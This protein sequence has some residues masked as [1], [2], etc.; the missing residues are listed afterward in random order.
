MRGLHRWAIDGEHGGD[1][2]LAITQGEGY[3]VP[4][5]Q[6]QVLLVEL[7]REP[8]AVPEDEGDVTLLEDAL[9]DKGLPLRYCDDLGQ[10]V[11]QPDG[12]YEV[13]VTESL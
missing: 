7:A 4:L 10:H 11:G 12:V 5:H 9:V 8:F 1:E 6:L 3:L 2:V 13:E